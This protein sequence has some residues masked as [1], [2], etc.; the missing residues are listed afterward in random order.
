MEPRPPDTHSLKAR[1]A[2]FRC[3]MKTSEC[4]LARPLMH[5]PDV[6]A[7]HAADTDSNLLTLLDPVSKSNWGKSSWQRRV[8]QGES[9]DFLKLR[10]NSCQTRAIMLMQPP[11]TVYRGKLAEPSERNTIHVSNSKSSNS[12]IKK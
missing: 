2:S 4:L 6:K 1:D 3:Q 8:T 5:I 12:H 10:H 11:T 7:P 9:G